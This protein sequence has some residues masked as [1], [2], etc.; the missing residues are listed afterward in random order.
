MLFEKRTA[1]IVVAQI[2]LLRPIREGAPRMTYVIAIVLA[3]GFGRILAIFDSGPQEAVV[4]LNVIDFDVRWTSAIDMRR[5][6]L[7]RLGSNNVLLAINV[8]WTLT[9]LSLPLFACRVVDFCAK[10]VY[11]LF[12]FK[13]PSAFPVWKTLFVKRLTNSLDRRILAVFFG[14]G[15]EL[16]AKCQ[17]DL[18][19]KAYYTAAIWDILEPRISAHRLRMAVYHIKCAYSLGNGYALD[20]DESR[21]LSNPRSLVYRPSD[22][23][24]TNL[25]YDRNDV[26]A[27]LKVAPVPDLR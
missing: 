6:I 11:Q 8:A 20:P 27:M 5:A 21:L 16:Y 13:V 3:N 19:A 25:P 1:F 24:V 18:I 15:I 9:A 17:H 14:D 10:E 4:P 2:A 22:L 23:P 12:C 7:E 26:L